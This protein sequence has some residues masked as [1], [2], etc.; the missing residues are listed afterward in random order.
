M[1][2]NHADW[3]ILRTTGENP[4]EINY[5]GDAH[6]G[7]DP[8]YATGIEL[9]RALQDYA[10]D[11]SDGTEEI[12][13]VDKIPSQRGGVDTNITLVNGY[14][15][16]P[17]AAEHLYDTSISQT[18]PVNDVQ[19]YDGIQVFGNATSIQVIQDGARLTNDFWN[20]AKM[21]AAVEDATSSTTHHFMVLVRNGGV[22]I[23]GRRLIGTQRVYG[24]TYT[25][26]SI[27][28]GTNRGNNVLALTANTNLNN[29]T[30][31]ATINA[32][33][34]TIAQGYT[35]ID[36]DGSGSPENYYVE[37]R[38]QSPDTKNQAYEYSQNMIRE[39]AS[40]TPVLGT[41][42][43][44][45]NIF[46]GITHSVAVS[47]GTGTWTE[48][49]ELSWG[50]GATAGT[51]QLLAVDNTTASS[52]TILYIQH[53]TGI[54]PNANPIS[55]DGGG[56][57]TATAGAVTGQVVSIPP[58]GASTGTNI[59]GAYGVGINADDLATGDTL[60]DLSGEKNDAPNNV[61][62]DVAGLNINTTPDY[63][64]VGPDSGG[65]LNLAQMANATLLTGVTTS[66]SVGTGNIPAD[67]PSIGTI[68]IERNSGEYTRHP[69]EA[70]DATNTTFTITSCDF[71]NDPVA[72]TNN[73]FISYIDKEA[74]ETTES[75]NTV[76]TSTRALRVIVRNGGTVAGIAPI[77]P[78]DTAGSL[79]SGGGSTTLSR[80]LD[81]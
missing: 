58:I 41:F 21:I 72:A 61:Q 27:G 7:A 8:T 48:P 70:F 45:P 50:T 44:D 2:W 14:H 40:A 5:V 60:I 52:S 79:G 80:Q 31:Q 13:I 10:D 74:T 69:Y 55:G 23:D 30:V 47:G 76:F 64:I 78:I 19:V 25:E 73:I 37:W 26:F 56:F 4:L 16:T 22:D 32:L 3:T 18:H 65:A 49:E 66:V 43:L 39:G 20:E 81:T 35:Q 75:F 9:H 68:R 53:L 36:A 11:Q 34:F 15:I 12:S 54:L 63:V 29:S 6:N 71:T 67:T 51:G 38:V 1:T 42:G 28:G 46:R 62:F 57:P 17:T 33:T 24:T 77:V 59:K